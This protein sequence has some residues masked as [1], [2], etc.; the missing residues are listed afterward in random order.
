MLLRNSS[1]KGKATKISDSFMSDLQLEFCYNADEYLEKRPA[2]GTETVG[3]AGLGLFAKKIIPDNMA[4]TMVGVPVELIDG[5][6]YFCN[7]SINSIIAIGDMEGP[8][9]L[10]DLTLPVRV[11]D[12]RFIITTGGSVGVEMQY[13]RTQL[14]GGGCTRYML[15]CF[16]QTLKKKAF[17]CDPKWTKALLSRDCLPAYANDPTFMELKYEWVDRDIGIRMADSIALEVNALFLPCCDRGA[18]RRSVFHTRAPKDL[19]VVGIM[20]V[21][22]KEV[23][24]GQQIGIKYNLCGGTDICPK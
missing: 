4:F 3:D 2:N 21:L 23:L 5:V 6:G 7:A 16:N 8:S 18:S 9:L 19:A 20:M 14:R 22:N 12:D 11:K 17:N 13:E 15:C 10:Q 1:I 24:K